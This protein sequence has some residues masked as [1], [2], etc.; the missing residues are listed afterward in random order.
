MTPIRVSVQPMSLPHGPRETMRKLR[1]SGRYALLESALPMPRQAN[2]S[3]IAGPGL[4]TLS[5][6]ESA[7]RLE[8]DAIESVCWRD[9]LEAL[10]SVTR[11]D[12][13]EIEVDGERPAG[14]DFIGGWVGAL[15]YDLARDIER[16]PC[17]ARN[18]PALPRQWWMAVDQVL[19][20][21]HPSGQWWRATAC[22]PR[23][24]WP[25]TREDRASA[26]ARTLELAA[27]P[28]PE[29]EL[30]CA[31]P[32]TLRTSRRQ[33]E[34]GVAGI[35]GR[36]AKGDVLQVN[37]TR[38][39]DAAF[40]GDPWSLYEDLVRAHPA[41]F[42]AYLEGPGFAIAS[43]SPERFLHVRGTDVEARPIKGTIARGSDDEE[44]ATRRSALAASVKDRAE[45]LMIVDLIRNDLGRVAATGSVRVPELFA[46]EPYTSVWQMVSTV[47]A[48]LRPEH[49][50][51]DLLRAC[52]PPGSMTGA[53]KIKA[54][55]IIEALEPTRRGWYAGSI[56][57]MDIGGN[58]DLS[59]V[60]RTAVVAQGHVMV[61]FGG[62]IVADSEPAAEWA[63][64]VAKGM[65]LTQTLDR[66][67]APST[68][69]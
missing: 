10:A 46:L 11:C 62:G 24:R 61:Q 19:A 36:I 27:G 35:G 1:S 39:E 65:R 42:A 29:R 21:H 16:L 4:A 18:D 32:R 20:F 67:I 57:Y 40:D 34:Q 12:T 28:L 13:R 54:M 3:Y 30:W 26:W 66:G 59:V 64:T 33:F 68:G 8:G 50:R 44:D 53:P 23:D 52:W 9:P 51:V 60:I 25:W 69:Q 2:W 63:E 43:C 45:N 7:T 15:G 58:M 17:E 5:T 48:R 14:M 37:L 56:G 38:R 41:P 22:G 31:G 49:Q 55:E 6:D 47:T